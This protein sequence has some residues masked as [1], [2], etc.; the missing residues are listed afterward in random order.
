MVCLLQQLSHRKG[1]DARFHVFMQHF[2]STHA[3]KCANN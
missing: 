2:D 3:Y 1:E